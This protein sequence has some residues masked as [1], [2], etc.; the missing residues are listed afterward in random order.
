MPATCAQCSDAIND[1]DRVIVAYQDLTAALSEPGTAPYLY[2]VPTLMHE[3]HWR[4]AG[5]WFEAVRASYRDT[6][7][8]TVSHTIEGATKEG[9]TQ[10]HIRNPALAVLTGLGWIGR[11]EQQ[12]ARG[13]DKAIGRDAGWLNAHGFALRKSRL[14]EPRQIEIVLDLSGVAAL[15]VD[16]L[17]SADR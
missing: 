2:V 13:D 16:A 3:R 7:E 10:F 6:M 4:P 17:A 14:S 9:A 15:P 12:V 11:I 1:D 8:N 5:S